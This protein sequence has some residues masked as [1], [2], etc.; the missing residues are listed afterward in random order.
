MQIVEVYKPKS[1]AEAHCVQQLLEEA[2]IECQIAGEQLSNLYGMAVGWNMPSVLVVD[3]DAARARQLIEGKLGSA[4]AEPPPK[5]EF[6]FGMRALLMNFMLIAFI[7]GL[8]VP[9]GS[10]WE[11]FA[12]LSIMLLV[13]GNIAVFVYLRNKRSSVAEEKDANCGR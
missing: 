3:E 4:P 10:Y 9:L 1:I 5:L 11:D 8:Y 6:R 12:F 13:V 7:L 2:G